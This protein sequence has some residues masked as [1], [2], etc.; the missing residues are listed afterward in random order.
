MAMLLLLYNNENA[1]PVED[2]AFSAEHFVSR[3]DHSLSH[4]R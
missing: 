2:I 1:L 4:F 3:M